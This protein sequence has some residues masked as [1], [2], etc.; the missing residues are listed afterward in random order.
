MHRNIRN[1][2]SLRKMRYICIHC[3]TL[4][5]TCKANI[6]VSLKFAYV[7][8]VNY[9]VFIW[10]KI[11]SSKNVLLKLKRWAACCSTTL[12]V[13]ILVYVCIFRICCKIQLYI[14]I[15]KQFPSR[16]CETKLPYGKCIP[17]AWDATPREMSSHLTGRPRY[18]NTNWILF[19]LTWLVALI[20]AH[21]VFRRVLAPRV[22]CDQMR[23]IC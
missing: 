2:A 8:V 14:K 15:G 20:W 9:F 3:I 23:F 12:V 7:I 19:A 5:G 18:M 22:F 17:L 10:N 6:K 1:E 21:I 16:S 13:S 11:M 4:M